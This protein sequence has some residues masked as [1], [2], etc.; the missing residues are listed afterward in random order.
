MVENQRSLG[1]I[2]YLDYD[3]FEP[4]KIKLV[5]VDT[6][7]SAVLNGPPNWSIEIESGPKSGP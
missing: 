6:N 4:S 2:S 1:R 5:L 3:M 7:W